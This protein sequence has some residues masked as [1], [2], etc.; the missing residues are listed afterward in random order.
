[1]C[2][3]DHDTH[4]NDYVEGARS[5]V[6]WDHFGHFEMALCINNPTIVR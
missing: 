4:A 1:M 2:K 5:L 6:W 3:N